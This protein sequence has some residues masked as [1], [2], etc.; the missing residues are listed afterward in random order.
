MLS[1]MELFSLVPPMPGDK[2]AMVNM[3]V[4][5][6]IVIALKVSQLLMASRYHPWSIDAGLYSLILHRSF[7]Y[8]WSA[9]KSS[10]EY[11]FLV[12]AVAMYLYRTLL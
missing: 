6:T 1:G 10:C 12:V 2:M 11:A 5:V 9:S 7:V 4:F 3:A 8:Q